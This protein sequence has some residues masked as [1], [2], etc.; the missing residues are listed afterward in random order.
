MMDFYSD[1][2]F[3]LLWMFSCGGSADFDDQIFT[4]SDRILNFC[5]VDFQRISIFKKFLFSEVV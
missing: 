5:P 3:L 1:V 2:F 4:D